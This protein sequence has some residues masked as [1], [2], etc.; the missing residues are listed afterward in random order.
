MFDDLPE[1]VLSDLAGRVR[2]G[3]YP[4]GKP[5]FRQGDRPHALYVVRT[6][7]LQVIEEDVETGKERVI[8][9][10]GRGDMFGELGLIDGARRSATVRPVEDAQLFEVDES[11]FDRLL[12]DMVH[13]PDFAPTLQRAAELRTLGPFA[14]LSGSDVSLL[15][16]HGVWVNVPPGETVITQGEEG[17]AFYV[18]GAGPSRGRPGRPD[19]RD[20]GAADRISARSRS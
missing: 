3:R 9:T 6:G 14:G 1:D 18:V 20:D 7:A 12:A 10:L 4:A 17:D 2:L 15:L 11:T 16:D 8:R 13:V 19:H 5:V